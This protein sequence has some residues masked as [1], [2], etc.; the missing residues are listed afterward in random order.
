MAYDADLA[1][2]LRAVL[3]GE[4]DLSEKRMFGG[5]AFLL[6]GR[7]TVAASGRGGVLVR[8]DPSRT[9]QL[10]A[11]PH[12]ERMVMR[13]RQMDGWLHVSDAAAATDDQLRAWVG[14]A[15]AY[16]RLL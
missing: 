5:L 7:L 8:C 6:G 15:V 4:R 9:D 12:V 16:V 13:G 2:R 14:E 11:R 1:E 10:V 3:A